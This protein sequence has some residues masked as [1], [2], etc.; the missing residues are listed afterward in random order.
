MLSAAFSTSLACFTTSWDVQIRS[1]WDMAKPVTAAVL[2]PICGILVRNYETSGASTPK[3]GW[4]TWAS[5]VIISCCC[6]GLIEICNQIMIVNYMGYYDSILTLFFIWY[7]VSH[8][9][10][11]LYT[12]LP[13]NV[14]D[15]LE[16]FRKREPRLT[17]QIW[18]RINSESFHVSE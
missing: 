7:A 1:V 4:S 11:I 18:Q 15:S 17:V 3:W 2:L 8:V 6:D 10:V 13:D 16:Y 9:S 5:V 12:S 14:P